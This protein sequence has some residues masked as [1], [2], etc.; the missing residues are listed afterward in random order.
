MKTSFDTNLQALQKKQQFKIKLCKS[1]NTNN[2]NYKKILMLK[3]LK[4]IFER[5]WDWD[6]QGVWVVV[7][8]QGCSKKTRRGEL[9]SLKSFSGHCCDLEYLMSFVS[10]R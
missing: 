4:M 8:G 6:S 2:R 3:P 10:H 7:L 9:M 1:S 5:A